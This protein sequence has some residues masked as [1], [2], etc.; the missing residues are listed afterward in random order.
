M[1]RSFFIVVFFLDEEKR[2]LCLLIVVSD[3]EKIDILYHQ[4]KVSEIRRYQSRALQLQN[5]HLSLNHLPKFKST[6]HHGH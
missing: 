3:I 2:S 5:L 6:V 4:K 1:K